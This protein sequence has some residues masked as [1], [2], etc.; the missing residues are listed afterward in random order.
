MKTIEWL[1]ALTA[2][3]AP[4]LVFGFALLILPTGAHCVGP[5]PPGLCSRATIAVREHTHA[6]RGSAIEA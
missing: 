1:S 3:F 5:Q 2:V 4:L 6:N